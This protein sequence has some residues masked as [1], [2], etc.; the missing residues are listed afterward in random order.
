VK[1]DCSHNFRFAAD[2]SLPRARAASAAAISC[3]D[4]AIASRDPS[5][6]RQVSERQRNTLSLQSARLAWCSTEMMSRSSIAIA[7]SPVVADQSGASMCPTD[8]IYTNCRHKKSSNVTCV[9]SSKCR[10]GLRQ[11]AGPCGGPL[12][13]AVYQFLEKRRTPRL[14]RRLRRAKLSRKP[15]G[16]SSKAHLFWRSARATSRKFAPTRL[17]AL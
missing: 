8:K 2:G 9:G 16:A 14:A 15:T 12:R 3:C 5:T 10:R 4:C 13:L 7:P 6:R 17:L 1:S 11:R